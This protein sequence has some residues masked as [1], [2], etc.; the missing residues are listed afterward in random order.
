MS[1]SGVAVV[2]GGARGIGRAVAAALAADGYHIVILDSGVE[3][4]GTAPGAQPAAAAA[5]E[6]TAAGGSAEGVAGDAGDAGA[7]GRVIAGVVSRHGPVGVLANVAGI[8]RPG[9]FLRDTEE[10]WTAVL[11]AHLGGHL[12]AIA[13]V[14]PGMAAQGRG[15]IIN[16][17]STAALL[18]SRRQPAYSTAKQA[19]VGLTRALA[20]VLQPSGIAVN[21]ISPAAESRMSAGAP[22]VPDPVRN[23]LSAELSDRGPGH[24]GAFA[25]WLTG[26]GAAGISGRV[27]L[28]SGHYVTEY[29]HMRPWKWSAVPPGAGRELVAERVRWVLGRPHP[30]VI[31]PWPTRDF[32]L[33]E[34]DRLWEGTGASSGLK[35][36]A[37]ADRRAAAPPA[38]PATGAAGI[39]VFGPATG[40]PAAGML[41][42]MRSTDAAGPPAAGAGAVVVGPGCGHRRAAPLSLP[43]PAETCA[44]VGQLLGHVQSALALA[45]RDGSHSVVVML[46][47]WPGEEASDLACTLLRYAAIGLIRGSAATETVYGV[48]VNGL[49][50]EPGQ[51]RLAATVAEYLL[52]SGS[53]WLNG[54]IL[55]ADSLGVGVLSDERPRWQGY[56]ADAGFRLPPAICRELGMRPPDAA[57]PSGYLANES[58]HR[59]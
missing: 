51:E 14:L 29:E 13:A 37:E 27:F 59:V 54:Y 55:T 44:A 9:P 3:L 25:R 8:L 53:G 30:A 12:A 23:Q 17:T 16:V 32:G 41:A 24:V 47:P 7:V 22:P 56:F 21:A 11:S 46:P 48:R 33:D 5:R 4:D 20:P 57:L 31:G 19:I 34:A 49:A 39:A 36:A 15:H 10:T 1:T 38:V 2:T 6:I 26:P 43:P 35:A 28:V 52:S 45:S 18:G 58:D 50:A 42:L 40:H